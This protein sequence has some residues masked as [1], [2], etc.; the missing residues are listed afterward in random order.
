MHKQENLLKKGFDCKYVKPVPPPT[1]LNIRP[2]VI[3]LP[4][5]I[6]LIYT[7]DEGKK[8]LNNPDSMF[9]ILF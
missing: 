4:N 6:T 9:D 8:M 1:P 2:L 5:A 7:S 3:K